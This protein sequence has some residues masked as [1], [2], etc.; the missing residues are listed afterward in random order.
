M[1]KFVRTSCATEGIE[2]SKKQR[3]NVV[4][5]IFLSGIFAIDQ[6]HTHIIFVYFFSLSSAH[7]VCSLGYAIRPVTGCCLCFYP[8]LCFAHFRIYFRLHCQCAAEVCA[9]RLHIINVWIS[10][11][12][13]MHNRHTYPRE[14]VVAKFDV[15][16]FSARQINQKLW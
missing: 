1:Q 12:F 15:V 14:V 13:E 4:F 9:Y 7:S 2:S 11:W 8:L 5:F 16:A 6:S 3:T 10:V